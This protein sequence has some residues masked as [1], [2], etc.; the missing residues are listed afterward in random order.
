VV[1]VAMAAA[2]EATGSNETFKTFDKRER[3]KRPLPFFILNSAVNN[4]VLR[5]VSLM[6]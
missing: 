4:T 2:A 5:P 6:T 1:V 3:S